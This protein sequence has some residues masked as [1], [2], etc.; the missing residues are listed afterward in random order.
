MIKQKQ[1]MVQSVNYIKTKHG[2]NYIV[3]NYSNYLSITPS[4]GVKYISDNT[5]FDT[6]SYYTKKIAYLHK[7]GILNQR[8][9]LNLNIK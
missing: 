7:M 6:S 5:E 2:N 3:D 8:I 9:I 1:L 4:H